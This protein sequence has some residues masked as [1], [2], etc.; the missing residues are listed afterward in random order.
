MAKHWNMNELE[1]IRSKALARAR[2]EIRIRMPKYGYK[3]KDFEKLV[4]NAE[5]FIEEFL[6]QAKREK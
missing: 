5:E 3:E 2:S 6:S 1:Y 4:K